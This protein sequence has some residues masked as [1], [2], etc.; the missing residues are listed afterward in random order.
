VGFF[1]L[2]GHDRQSLSLGNEGLVPAVVKAN[3]RTVVVVTAPGAVTMPWAT[4][5][6]AVVLNFLPGQEAG[7]ALADVLLGRVNPSA[8]LPIT[9][10]VGENDMNFTRSQWPV[11]R[12]L[13]FGR[14]KNHSFLPICNR[15]RTFP[16]TLPIARSCLWAIG[17]TRRT[18]SSPTS[19][20]ATV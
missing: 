9:M 12:C 16:R 2:Q 6:A 10:P 3:A 11:R 18:T 13:F 1:L 17:G 20:L 4:D 5:A 14:K 15:A 8:R 19:R 7:N